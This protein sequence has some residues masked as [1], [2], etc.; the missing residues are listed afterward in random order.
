MLVNFPCYSF[1]G[2]NILPLV[3]RVLNGIVYRN[4]DYRP[5]AFIRD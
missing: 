1:A 3:K 4:N 5:S 2:F